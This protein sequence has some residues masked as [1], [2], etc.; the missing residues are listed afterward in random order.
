MMDIEMIK[1][2]TKKMGRTESKYAVVW[3]PK[4]YGK[5]YRLVLVLQLCSCV[6]SFLPL[7]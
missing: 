4:K 7:A 6:F 2:W 5:K 1:A 3:L